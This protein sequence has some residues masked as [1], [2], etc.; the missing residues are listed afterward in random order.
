[1]TLHF[2]SKQRQKFSGKLIVV[3]L[4]HLFVLALLAQATHAATPQQIESA[5]NKAKEAI[6]EDQNA[7]GTWETSASPKSLVGGAVNDQDGLQWGGR[8][9][10][11]VYAMLTIGEKSTEP[12]LVKAI[13]FL[14]KQP[15]IN[16]T[17]A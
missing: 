10:M 7:N 8:T 14:Q 13:E 11:A 6:Y 3:V 12:K 2:D 16:G 17:Y 15:N 9:A 5:I 4:L 1:M